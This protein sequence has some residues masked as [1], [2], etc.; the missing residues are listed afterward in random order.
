MDKN[1]L[2]GLADNPALLEEVKKTILE[3]FDDIPYE[4]GV[5]DEQL[6]Q[7]TR[8]RI[9]GRIQVEKAFVKISEWKSTDTVLQKE[10]PAY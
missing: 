2:T 4:E 7:I 10:N 8:A 3:H 1:I 6:G 9:V 5:S